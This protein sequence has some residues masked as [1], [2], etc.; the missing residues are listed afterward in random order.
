MPEKNDSPK[1]EKCG[2]EM[3]FEPGYQNGKVDH[4]GMCC[5]NKKCKPVI[6]GNQATKLFVDD[7]VMTP[8]ECLE[9]IKGNRY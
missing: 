1:C 2:T 5:P 9:Q 4:I 6:R 3:I 7:S 8:K